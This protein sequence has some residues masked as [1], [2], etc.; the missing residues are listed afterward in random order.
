MPVRKTKALVEEK[1]TLLKMTNKYH[2][3]VWYARSRP[4]ENT[5]YWEGVDPQIKEGAAKNQQRIEKEYPDE[6]KRLSEETFHTSP[7]W[8]HGFNSGCL[9]SF[10]FASEVLEQ[11]VDQTI[12]DFP[13]LDT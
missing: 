2:D 4:L 11:G 6:V 10:R 9:A 7:D 5:E 8:E 13:R 3:L 12:Q 1:E